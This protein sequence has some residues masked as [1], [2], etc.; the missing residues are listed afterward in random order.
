MTSTNHMNLTWGSQPRPRPVLQTIRIQRFQV[1]E[2]SATGCPKSEMW[3]VW[4]IIVRIN[5]E[6]NMTA[7]AHWYSSNKNIFLKWW[8]NCMVFESRSVAT[9]N[10][11]VSISLWNSNWTSSC[12]CRV[13]RPPS[14]ETKSINAGV[15]PTQIV[16]VGTMVQT[17]NS[18]SQAATVAG[19][20]GNCAKNKVHTPPVQEWN[21]TSIN[22]RGLKIKNL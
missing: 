10:P 22:F 2:Q 12:S 5:V 19:R 18:E 3:C 13:S 6:K 7:H 17:S 4:K 21:A 11:F 14:G 20:V 9:P 1:R 15:L 8:S 16:L